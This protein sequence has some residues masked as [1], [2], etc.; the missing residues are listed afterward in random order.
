[1]L[2]AYLVKFAAYRERVLPQVHLFAIFMINLGVEVLLLFRMLSLD[3]RVATDDVFARLRLLLGD[4]QVVQQLSLAEALS[5]LPI[6]VTLR[7]LRNS[8]VAS[9][10][11]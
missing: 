6:A 11:R 4:V 9:G 5:V 7:D 1:M 8:F 10:G 3:G 2:L